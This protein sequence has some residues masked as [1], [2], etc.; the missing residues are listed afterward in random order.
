M[1][2]VSKT[3]QEHLDEL[4]RLRVDGTSSIAPEASDGA[5]SLWRDLSE[6]TGG[7]LR[8]PMVLPGPDRQVFFTWC[9]GSHCLEAEIRAG[10]PIVIAYCDTATDVAEDY[11]LET[12][13]PIP[14][15]LTERL[16]LFGSPHHERS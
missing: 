2:T 14:P 8:L 12:D 15:E 5:W 11:S 6:A 4:A 3:L 7:E 9:A 13:S 10:G 16:K 1:S